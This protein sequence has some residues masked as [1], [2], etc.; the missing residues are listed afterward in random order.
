MVKIWHY[1]A[2]CCPDSL[3]LIKLWQNVFRIRG[4]TMMYVSCHDKDNSEVSRART[5][6]PLLGAIAVQHP[7]LKHTP[8]LS[9]QGV[10][11]SE[12]R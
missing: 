6:P 2:L 1:R 5:P 8:L 4:P 11:D 10:K 3:A 7:S 12:E 9:S